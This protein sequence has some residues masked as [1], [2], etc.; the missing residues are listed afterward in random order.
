[1]SREDSSTSPPRKQLFYIN[2]KDLNGIRAESFIVVEH[3]SNQVVTGYYSKKVVEIA[4]LTKIMTFY[5]AVR[6][7]LQLALNPDK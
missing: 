5:T 7:Y 3:P 1:L 6:I 2:Q 4:S